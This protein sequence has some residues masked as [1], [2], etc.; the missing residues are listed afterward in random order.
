MDYTTW[1][2]TLGNG[3]VTGMMQTITKTHQLRILRGQK[4]AD[5]GCCGAGPGATLRLTCVSLT[6]ST[7][8]RTLRVI[9]ATLTDFDVCQDWIDYL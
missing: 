1:A 8:I 6:A 7:P 3:V 9:G 2:A 4:L 5:T